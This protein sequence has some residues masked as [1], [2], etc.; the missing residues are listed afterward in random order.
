M[1]IRTGRNFPIR[2]V[3]RSF[4]VQVVMKR[5]NPILKWALG[6]ALVGAMTGT[7]AQVTYVGGGP[8]IYD[9]SYGVELAVNQLMAHARLLENEVLQEKKDVDQL[10]KDLKAAQDKSAALE[11]RVRAMELRGK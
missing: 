3:G 2:A 9:R 5:V 1:G 8:Y 7:I 10:K 4:D 6:L 11:K